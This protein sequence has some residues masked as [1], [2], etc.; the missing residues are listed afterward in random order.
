LNLD[1]FGQICRCQSKLLEVSLWHR[2]SEKV[3]PKDQSGIGVD[4][5]SVLQT[6]VPVEVDLCK[7]DLDTEESHLISSFLVLGGELGANVTGGGVELH[8]DP[9]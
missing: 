8:H 3:L 2:I 4:R 6:K 5:E 1:P 7:D 9:I